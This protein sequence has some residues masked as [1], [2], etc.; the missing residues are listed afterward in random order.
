[1]SE[2]RSA[3]VEEIYRLK[4]E[5]DAVILAHNYQLPEVQDIADIIGDSLALARTAAK[6]SQS[7]IVFCGVH[8]MAESAAILAPTK[9]VLLPAIDAGCPLADMADAESLRKMREEY[10]DAAVVSYVN[11]SAE[12]KA[13]SD[14]CCTSANAVRVVQSLGEKRV[15]FVPDQNLAAYVAARVDKE[16]IPW[17]GYCPTH[18][19]LQAKDVISVKA[20]H[21]DALVLVHPEVRQEVAELAD[22]VGSTSQI[23]SFAKQTDAKTVIIGTE[24]GTL[25]QLQKDNEGKQFYLL[26][27]R[28]V[29]PNMKRTTLTHVRDSLE[30]LAPRITVDEGIR[31]RAVRALE[32]MIEV[33]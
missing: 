10:P 15:I 20:A 30:S 11:T 6:V 14:I 9:T 16:V 26:S 32:R 5:R 3:L 4:S 25:H 22:F 18:H 17:P 7:V 29:C 33:G 1:M 23:L 8:F 2:I 28:L 24:M 31:Q 13:E 27:P 12:V 21:P 19:R